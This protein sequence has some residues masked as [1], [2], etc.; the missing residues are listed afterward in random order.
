MKLGKRG[1]I[2][3]FIIIGILIVISA[4]LVIYLKEQEIIFRP[5]PPVIPDEAVPINEFV[6]ICIEN[7]GEDATNMVGTTGGYVNIPFELAGNPMSFIRIS[8][9]DRGKMPYWYYQGEKRIPP[10]EFIELEIADYVTA[11]LKECVLNLEPFQDQYDIK[12]LGEIYTE[13]VATE[14]GITI[15]VSY[16]IEISDKLGRKITSF[17]KFNAHVNYRLKKTYEFAVEI[18]EEENRNAKL[19]DIT[20]D[21]LALDPE[22]PYS[23]FEFSCEEKRW[24]IKDIENKLKTLL[25]SNLPLIR[26]DKTN[27][28]PIPA[29]QPYVQNHYLWDVSETFYPTMSVSVTYDDSWPLYMYVRPNSGSYI[30]SNMQKGMDM[31]SWLCMQTYKFTYDV[32]YPVTVTV[33]DEK[34]DYTFRFAFDVLI[35]HNNANRDSFGTSTFE[36]EQNPREEEYCNRKL[37]EITVYTYENVSGDFESHLEIDDVNL[38]FTCLKFT[39]PVGKTEFSGPVGVSTDTYPYC[40]WGILRGYKEGYKTGE[41]FIATDKPGEYELY[42]TPFTK[43]DKYSVVKHEL[44]YSGEE[45]SISSVAEELDDDEVASIT[46]ERVDHKTFGSYPKDDLI[47]LELLAYEDFE[48]ELQIYLSDGESMTGGYIANW[49][50]DWSELELTDEIV[51][52]TV[53]MPKFK[54][55]TEQ[56]AFLS[57]IGSYSINVPEPELR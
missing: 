43:L 54:D 50:A 47:E 8:P 15:E 28:R 10:L 17:D 51:F 21:L 30:S 26:F 24:E 13:V 38:T 56:F 55:D 9:L 29:N 42:L 57:G 37:N 1:Q 34:S 31:I 2:T 45:Y 3:I 19:E 5:K 41:M 46:L 35:D 16:P 52:H 49:T 40:V 20:I 48:Y 6:E 27:Y 33:Y 23:N 18:M 44:T 7:I 14:E 12:E 32:V 36:F 25:R 53:Y 11:N 39:C 4:A 22:I